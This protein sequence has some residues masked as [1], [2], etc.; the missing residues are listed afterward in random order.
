MNPMMQLKAKLQRM[1]KEES[2]TEDIEDSISEAGS[3]SEEKVALSEYEKIKD[4]YLRLAADFDNFKKRS[5]KE[6][7]LSLIH[8]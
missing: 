6:R 4:E 2:S 5:E 3:K 8:I 7:D 1:N